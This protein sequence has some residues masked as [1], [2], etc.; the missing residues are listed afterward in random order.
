M[1]IIMS[2]QQSAIS[3]LVSVTL[4]DANPNTQVTAFNSKR[5]SA[6]KPEL[7][8]VNLVSATLANTNPNTQVTAFCSKRI[9][10]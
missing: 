5:I 4:A 10:A 7:K 6:H 1:E 9:A 3:N 8:I 2:N